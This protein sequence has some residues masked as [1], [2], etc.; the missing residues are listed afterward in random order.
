M[1]YVIGLVILLLFVIY[2]QYS[3]K[4]NFI[5]PNPATEYDLIGQTENYQRF[6]SSNIE[7][8]NI[9]NSNNLQ[10]DCDVI[11]EG[12]I[13]GKYC[14]QNMIIEPRWKWNQEWIERI[15]SKC[16]F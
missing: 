14:N 11:N 13:C 8:R 16:F 2:K 7:K 3:F 9:I 6:F 10:N 1:E 5:M 15:K 4:E 12:C